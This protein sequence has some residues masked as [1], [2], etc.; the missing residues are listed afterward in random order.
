MTGD[1]AGD[2][3]RGPARK[4]D[5]PGLRIG[6][7]VWVNELGRTGADDPWAHRKGEPRTFT[8]LWAIY[9]MVAALL[10]IFAVPT[11]SGAGVRQWT[12]GCQTMMLLVFVGVCVLWPATRLSQLSP[13]RPRRATL[14]DLSIMLIPVQAVVWPMPLLTGWTWI[15]TL[16]L[17]LAVAGWGVLI[18]AVLARGC[19]SVRSY[20]RTW[21]MGAVLAL[22]AMGPLVSVVFDSSLVSRGASLPGWW[23]LVSPL[24][25]SHAMT[26]TPM[27]LT[28]SMSGAEWAAG[29]APLA[30]GCVLWMWLARRPDGVG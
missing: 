25:L 6:P 11:L 27:N 8:L 2:E 14:V 4:P 13:E 16:G 10:T 29:W 18:G 23:A 1:V 17:V 5:V 26:T 7:F 28:P 15:V 9:L 21:A 30:V 19:A 3:G 22:V 20:A 24:T 12:Y